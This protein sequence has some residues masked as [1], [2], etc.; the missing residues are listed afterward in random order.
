MKDEKEFQAAYY[1]AHRDRLRQRHRAYA[2]AVSQ[3]KRIVVKRKVK[4]YPAWQQKECQYCS[5][6][7]FGKPKKVYFWGR[8]NGQ[9]VDNGCYTLLL[10][11]GVIDVRQTEAVGAVDKL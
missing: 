4:E 1:L 5:D 2:L 10:E 7:I 8:K 9:I 6:T 3:G 11:K